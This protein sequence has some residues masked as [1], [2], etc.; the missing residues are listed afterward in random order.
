[1]QV[2]TMHDPLEN[3]ADDRKVYAKWGQLEERVA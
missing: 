2:F 3:L 1:M